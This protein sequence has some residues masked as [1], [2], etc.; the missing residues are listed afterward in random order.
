MTARLDKNSVAI[1]FAAYI[2]EKQEFSTAKA[3]YQCLE[4]YAES[5]AKTV[6][7]LKIEGALAEQEDMQRLANYLVDTQYVAEQA[8]MVTPSV[9]DEAAIKTLQKFKQ[10]L[11]SPAGHAPAKDCEGDD[12]SAIRRLALRTE[13]LATGDNDNQRLPFSQAAEQAAELVRQRAMIKFQMTIPIFPASLRIALSQPEAFQSF[14]R[15]YKAGQIFKD[16]NSTDERGIVQWVFGENRKFLTFGRANS[17]ADAAANYVYMIK[18]PP[19][20]FSE[21]EPVGDFSELEEW[22]SLGGAPQ[23][24]DV[25]VLIAIKAI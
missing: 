4:S 20:D 22:Q 8:V 12:H 23:N 14:S 11:P 21:R 3:A 6:P 7:T 17:L 16:E 5:A 10:A 1:V 9:K 15:A 25:F 2:E 18:N 19:L 13:V 24:E